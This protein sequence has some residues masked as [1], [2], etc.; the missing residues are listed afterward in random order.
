[1]LS[2]EL[3]EPNWK[4]SALPIDRKYQKGQ[5][6]DN[7]MISIMK[8]AITT[9]HPQYSINVNYDTCT[10]HIHET[11]EIVICVNFSLNWPTLFRNNKWYISIYDFII[12]FKIFLQLD[13]TEIISPYKVPLYIIK[14]NNNTDNM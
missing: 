4:S 3:W 12:E 5:S 6:R 11:R 9:C 10:S 8:V 2:V 13:W 14:N 1:M 7:Y